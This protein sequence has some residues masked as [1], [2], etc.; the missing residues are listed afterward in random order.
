MNGVLGQYFAI[1]RLYGPGEFWANEM[2]FV[3]NHV[4]VARLITKPDDQQSST[5]PLY[6]GYPLA[7]FDNT[8]SYYYRHSSH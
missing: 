7:T 1:V 3:M 6:R 2:K 8:E 5:L 4:R